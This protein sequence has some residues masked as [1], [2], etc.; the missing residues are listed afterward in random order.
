M[1]LIFQFSLFD[2]SFASLRSWWCLIFSNMN[3]YIWLFLFQECVSRMCQKAEDVP[4]LNLYLWIS[5]SGHWHYKSYIWHWISEIFKFMHWTLDFGNIS[6]RTMES[7]FWLYFHSYIGLSTWNTDLWNY[8]WWTWCEHGAFLWYWLTGLF[9][10]PQNLVEELTYG[11]TTS[12][13]CNGR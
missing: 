5:S 3:F 7:R 8:S 13:Q 1:F 11:F 2:L 9:L 4:G 6:V 12:W 10:N